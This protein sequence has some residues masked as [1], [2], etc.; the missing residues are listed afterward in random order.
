MKEYISIKQ[1]QNLSH[2]KQQTFI[3]HAHGLSFSSNSTWLSCKSFVLFQVI[4]KNKYT[5][6]IFI[7]GSKF[8]WTCFA[9]VDGES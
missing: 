3:F 7:V 8:P 4:D 1:L 2:F 6:Y 9:M 5:K